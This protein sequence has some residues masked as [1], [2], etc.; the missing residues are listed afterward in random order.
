[1]VKKNPDKIVEHRVTTQ[2]PP[3]HVMGMISFAISILGLFLSYVIPFLLQIIALIL[4]H[5]A[6]KD[7]NA[8]PDRYSGKGF[9]TASLIIS[10]VIIGLYLLAIFVFGAG[11]LGLI[12]LLSR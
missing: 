10:Y 5:M 11:L 1:M 6:L 8:Q 2:M 3:L 4:G 7:F 9:V 12:G